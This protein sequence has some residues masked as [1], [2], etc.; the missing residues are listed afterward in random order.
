MQ[1]SLPCSG[2]SLEVEAKASAILSW[3]KFTLVLFHALYSLL[4][5][6]QT[7]N[8][9]KSCQTYNG[10]ELPACMIYLSPENS[11]MLTHEL[12][13]QDGFLVQ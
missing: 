12:T 7:N 8:G 3:H 13:L 2:C 11:G 1:Y 5:L 4:W 10:N 6:C 9:L